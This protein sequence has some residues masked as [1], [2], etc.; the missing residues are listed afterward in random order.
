MYFYEPVIE[1]AETK[2]HILLTMR[3]CKKKNVFSELG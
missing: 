3:M 1:I 2:V